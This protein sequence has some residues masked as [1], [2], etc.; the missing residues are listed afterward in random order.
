[1]A[2]VGEMDQEEYFQRFEQIFGDGPPLPRG[3]SEGGDSGS[4]SGRRS[5]SGRGRYDFSSQ[6]ISDQFS[7]LN[8]LSNLPSMLGE[9]YDGTIAAFQS[10]FDSMIANY[11][12]IQMAFGGLR[13]VMDDDPDAANAATKAAVERYEMMVNAYYNVDAEGDKLVQKLG[14]QGTEAENYFL[15][16]FE[17]FGEIASAQNA[18]TAVLVDQ[19]SQYVNAMDEATQSKIP[20]YT[21]ALDIS[22]DQV[23]TIIESQIA[24]T[25]KASTDILD[26]VAAYANKIHEETG[27]PIKAITRLS[28]QLIANTK[29]FGF[30]TAEAATMAAA[31]LTQLGLK[32]EDLE[33][34]SSG[35]DSFA[36]S[37]EKASKLAVLTEGKVKFDVAE[38]VQIASERQEELPE[39]IREVF[40]SSGFDKEDFLALTE[41]SRRELLS[42]LPGQFDQATFATF[43]DPDRTVAGN[44]KITESQRRLKETFVDGVP[45]FLEVTKLLTEVGSYAEG[46]AEK[47]EHARTAALVKFQR[48]AYNVATSLTDL[49]AT[50][51]NVVKIDALVPDDVT[52]KL[53]SFFEEAGDKIDDFEDHLSDP[54][55]FEELQKSMLETLGY[56]QEQ[57]E[58]LIENSGDTIAN[59]TNRFATNTIE[60]QEDYN[61]AIASTLNENDNTESVAADVAVQLRIDPSKVRLDEKEYDKI[62]VGLRKE[63]AGMKPLDVSA[64]VNVQPVVASLGAVDR[65]IKTYTLGVEG[66]YNNF[67]DLTDKIRNYD[68]AVSNR[69]TQ[70]VLVARLDQNISALN[71]LGTTIVEGFKLNSP[72]YKFYIQN[73][74]GSLIESSDG[75]VIVQQVST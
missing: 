73:G 19:H 48:E 8:Q 1:M 22:S 34:L 75:T 15:K 13:D 41:A 71:Q 31:S 43:L 3:S 21:K 67:K 46:S 59:I 57:I 55:K 25:G 42:V 2:T 30:T 39:Y 52:E 28:A 49:N 35:F 44:D 45:S 51:K 53:K 54:K 50:F 38:L 7:I 24:T 58:E 27:T 70:E 40:L 5:G 29:Q 11:D 72:N 16:Y 18:V 47:I 36:E 64:F 32:Y 60:I 33:S 23:A 26:S 37:A 68:P 74:D 66:T 12:K 63:I 6:A 56:T 62:S 10:D 65:N 20:A 69:E 17:S 9:A 4:S 61:E 14:L